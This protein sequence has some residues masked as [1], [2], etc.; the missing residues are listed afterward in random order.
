[1]H[2]HNVNIEARNIMFCKASSL[3]LTGK[4]APTSGYRQFYQILCINST[5]F[6]AAKLD[7]T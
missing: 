6:D 2:H 5:Y 3:M 7:A 4:K 1:M